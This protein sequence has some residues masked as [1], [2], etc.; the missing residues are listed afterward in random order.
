RIPGAETREALRAGRNWRRERPLPPRI[1]LARRL[2]PLLLAVLGAE[3]K[4]DRVGQA[5]VELPAG[6]EVDD[7][8]GDLQRTGVEGGRGRRAEA[9]V[10]RVPGEELQVVEAVVVAQVPG[11][12]A[13]VA[14]QSGH[15]RAVVGD[16]VDA[17]QETVRVD[18]RDVLVRV[19]GGPEER[20][21]G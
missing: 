20:E 3:G 9:G 5:P 18:L 6:I 7:V 16:V 2:V 14:A 12:A 8:L 15:D 1:R 19:A 11:P 4:V 17:G 13:G 21:R 10:E